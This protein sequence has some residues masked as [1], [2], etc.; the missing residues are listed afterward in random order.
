MCP[1]S[2]HPAAFTASFPHNKNLVICPNICKLAKLKHPQS[3]CRP[4]TQCLR[5]DTKCRQSSQCTVL[6]PKLISV[7]NSPGWRNTWRRG[8]LPRLPSPPLPTQGKW[9]EVSHGVIQSADTELT[10]AISNP[11]WSKVNNTH[12]W[13]H[14]DLLQ[15]AAAAMFGESLSSVP[16]NLVSKSLCQVC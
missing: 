12:C 11:I 9:E 8:E 10:M 5:G 13:F 16:R 6:F 1:W 14:V 3:S 4:M 15:N 7:H 2:Q